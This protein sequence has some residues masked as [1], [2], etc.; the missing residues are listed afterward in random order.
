[1]KKRLVVLVLIMSIA[2]FSLFAYVF[3]GT[4]LGI[5]GYP[6]YNCT[7]PNKMYTSYTNTVSKSQYE[8][9][10]RSVESYIE[11]A[12]EYIENCNS[13][14]KRIQ[15]AQKEALDSANKIIEEYNSWLRSVE[16]SSSCY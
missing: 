13:D 4:N 14:I 2:L 9:Y 10:K 8:S 11:G 16:I 6:S 7:K 12:E 15:E 3:G 5:S 1:M